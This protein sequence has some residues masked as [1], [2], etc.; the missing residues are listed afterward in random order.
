MRKWPGLIPVGQGAFDRGTTMDFRTSGTAMLRAPLGTATDQPDAWPDLGD[1]D[2]DALLVWL[3]HV[4]PDEAL[5]HA[6][7]ALADQVARLHLGSPTRDI[8]RAATA[9]A[10]YLLRAAHRPTPFGLFAG[11]ATARLG[12]RLSSRWGGRHQ[13]RARA[14]APWL[15]EVL[16]RLEAQPSLLERLSVVANSALMVR[17]G[18]LV[19]P[20]QPVS[21]E[22]KAAD[23][24]VRHTAA[25]RAA[26]EL[27]RTPIRFADLR[28]KLVA[29]FAVDVDRATRML[30]TL[31]ARR[32]LL[33]SLHAPAT[34]PDALGHI[35][36]ELADTVREGP[37]EDEGLYA[38][39]R[40]VHERMTGHN[41]LPGRRQ[42]GDLATRMQR[43]AT[44]SV[45]PLALDVRLD[46]ELTL[47]NTVVSEIERAAELLAR[48][49][50]QSRGSAAWR[51]YHRRFFERYGTGALVPLP[52]MIAAIGWPDGYPGTEEPPAPPLSERDRALLTLAQRAAISRQSELVLS[53]EIVDSLIANSLGSDDSVGFRAPSHLELVVRLHS[54]TED[55]VRRG[56]FLVEVSSVTR[57]VGVLSGRFHDLLGVDSV[58]LPVGDPDAVPAQLSFPPLHPRTAHIARGPDVLPAVISLGE[59]RGRHTG[60]AL[61][62]ADLAV[63]C[64][65]KRLF[66][67]AP[68][69]GV[70]IEPVGMHALNLST[71]TPP[72]ARLLSEIGRAQCAQVTAFD[73]G[74]AD[75]LPFLPHLRYGRIVLAA[76]RWRVTA[77][78]LPRAAESF[79]VWSQALDRWATQFR[80]PCVVRLAEHDQELTLD[81]RDPNH[82]FLL[83]EHLRTAKQ[84]LLREAGDTGWFRPHDLV[85]PLVATAPPEW[86]ALPKPTSERV[87]T[88][89]AMLPGRSRTL[90]TCLYGDA[91]D[92]NAL[93]GELPRLLKDLGD[94]AWWFLRYRDGHGH[95]LRLRLDTDDHG[96]ALDVIGGWAERICRA[97]LLRTATYPADHPE[98]GRWGRGAYPVAEEVFRTDSRAVVAQL[99]VEHD[100]DVR[101][102]AAVHF[103]AIAVAYL[104]SPEAGLQWLAERIA[105]CMSTKVGKLPRDLSQ[106]AMRLC[107]P[108]DRWAAL[109]ATP[110]GDAVSDASAARDQALA[111][112][113][114]ALVEPGIDSDAVL[115]SLL[116]VHFIRAVGIDPEAEAVALRLA[117]AAARTAVLAG[118]GRP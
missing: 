28:N 89:S 117:R 94:P 64:D 39:L 55:L 22:A 104:G 77:N 65:G 103:T 20:Y 24:V 106:D 19:L 23:L 85:V 1:A 10:R 112:Y 78:E 7:P 109:R 6:S 72:M 49:S 37:V 110:G 5:E 75:G 45:H 50:R 114:K 46:A 40:D 35:V 18:N 84:A 71:H 62:P 34:V 21:G 36:A 105:P 60:A 16:T 17:G 15:T 66:L 53:S 11:V 88:G 97:G 92:H 113:R 116:H 107:N 51:T 111:A 47:P 108:S 96:R 68:A 98:H 2:A 52:D 90:L 87:T 26:L 83:R 8:R 33:S 59:H 74:A 3:R 81:L 9:T 56:R 70:R 58:N 4:W 27:A 29:D 44:T 73:W 115:S 14:A 99:E 43:I 91:R 80:L 76:A 82:R 41:R 42:R 48:L 86:P 32:I 118:R 95:H 67:T 100:A 13:V 101:V 38:S 102:L 69:L 61:T 25:V 30:G 93:L 57:G 63:G 79:A 12:G 31:V 54:A